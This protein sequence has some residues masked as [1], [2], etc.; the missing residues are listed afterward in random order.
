M[1]Q[2]YQPISDEE[3]EK[4]LD[5]LCSGPEVEEFQARLANDPRAQQLIEIQREFD[6]KLRESFRPPDRTVEHIESWLLQPPTKTISPKAASAKSRRLLLTAV[7]VVAATIVWLFVANQWNGTRQL[8]PF[9][10]QRPLVAIYK[11]TVD[12]GFRP[13]YFCEDAERF[14][15]TFQ[16]RQAVPLL[17]ADTPPDRRMV[18]L[19]YL[20]G[21]SRDTTA[22]L[23][24]VEQQPVIVFVDRDKFDNPDLAKNEG[25]SNLYVHRGEL[26]HL[27]LYEV[28]PFKQPKMAEFIRIGR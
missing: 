25:D 28:S 14:A 24:Y 15:L 6:S 10:Q 26:G 23:S 8:K 11:E 4:Y 16:Q 2:F 21:L 22:M 9:F 17:L 12:R 18:G 3:L 27:V 13:Y 20:G 5:G 7:A 19:S 1:S